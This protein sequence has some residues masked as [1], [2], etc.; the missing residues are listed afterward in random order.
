MRTEA[1]LEVDEDIDGIEPVPPGPLPKSLVVRNKGRASR[2]IIS[3][4]DAQN[5]ARRI[6]MTAIKAEVIRGHKVLGEFV[7]QEGAIPIG[8]SMLLMANQ[9]LTDGLAKCSELLTHA[10]E[11]EESVSVLKALQLLAKAQVDA[12][13]SLIE[14]AALSDSVNVAAQNPT[15]SFLP[16]QTVVP[17]QADHVTI[18]THERT[19]V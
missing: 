7:E 13:N 16:H 4:S 19:G 18:Q 1:P 8:R 3:L 2:K 14:S 10:H 11:V 12:A 15:N 5:A 17:I 6:G 9:H